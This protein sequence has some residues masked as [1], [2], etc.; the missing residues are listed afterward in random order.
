MSLSLNLQPLILRHLLHPF[1]VAVTTRAPPSSPSSP[2]TISVLLPTPALVLAQA[3]EAISARQQ[4][5]ESCRLQE[6]E[7]YRLQ[8]GGVVLLLLPL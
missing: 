8:Q 2:A 6:Q 3:L 1:V 7:S 4:V 5:Q